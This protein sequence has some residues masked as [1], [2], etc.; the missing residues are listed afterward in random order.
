MFAMIIA[1]TWQTIKRRPSSYYS[2]QRQM[3]VAPP[4]VPV[5]FPIFKS[6]ESA[7]AVFNYTLS[8]SSSAWWTPP[9]GNQPPAGVIFVRRC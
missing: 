4:A 7:P 6:A 2:F 8:T 9:A 5:A 3:W 1:N